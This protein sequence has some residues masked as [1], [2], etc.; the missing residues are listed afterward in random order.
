MA[1]TA[2]IIL[3][4]TAAG[5]NVFSFITQTW[6]QIGVTVL[7]VSL[8]LISSEIVKLLYYRHRPQ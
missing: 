7:I 8:Y 3:L 1:F 2:A 5:R 4:F 6:T